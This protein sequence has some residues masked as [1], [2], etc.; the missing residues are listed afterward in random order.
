MNALDAY[1]LHMRVSFEA[2]RDHVRQGL[3]QIL[4]HRV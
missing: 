1:R 2:M 3:E 4:V